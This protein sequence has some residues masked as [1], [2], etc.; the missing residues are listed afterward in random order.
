M[1]NEFQKYPTDKQK[2]DE[3]YTRAFGVKCPRCNSKGLANGKI[4]CIKC[5]GIGYIKKE[6]A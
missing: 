4:T 5:G 1:I 6:K 3:N 2:F